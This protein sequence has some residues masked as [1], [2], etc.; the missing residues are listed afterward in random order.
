[1][2]ME[3]DKKLFKS[4]TISN[5]QLANEIQQLARS[6]SQEN[7]HHVAIKALLLRLYNSI[8]RLSGRRGHPPAPNKTIIEAYR[9]FF[10][11][12]EALAG[13]PMGDFL[14]ARMFLYLSSALI[15]DKS[16]NLRF[17]ESKAPASSAFLHEFC[18]QLDDGLLEPLKRIWIKDS[19]EQFHWVFTDCP[20]QRSEKSGIDPTRYPDL[21]QALSPEELK[22]IGGK[23]R[24]WFRSEHEDEPVWKAFCARLPDIDDQDTDNLL[25][26]D[27]GTD[28]PIFSGRVYRTLSKDAGEE[29][30]H[31]VPVLRRS[32]Q[33]IL[34]ARQISKPLITKQ[35]RHLLAG[36]LFRAAIP[37]EIREMI[38]AYMR[39]PPPP[40]QYNY[41]TGLDIAS[42][43]M[44][45]PKVPEPCQECKEK[46]LKRRD[47]SIKE[48]CPEHTI[49]VWNLL[50]RM[51]HVL[52]PEGN[53]GWWPCTEGLECCGHHDDEEWRVEDQSE[54]LGWIDS[55]ILD[56]DYEY[57]ELDDTGNGPVELTS[58]NPKEDEERRKRLFSENGPFVDVTEQ[59]KMEGGLCG[60][61]SVMAHKAAVIKA[62][63]D[64]GERR[65]ETAEV[66]WALGRNLVEQGKAEDTMKN[67]WH[68]SMRVCWFCRGRPPNFFSRRL[69]FPPLMEDSSDTDDD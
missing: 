61:L 24:Q 5:S 20:I 51:F 29:S 33:F 16:L 39:E 9:S 35:G 32:R 6:R 53:S 14:T 63:N 36:V 15:H 10:E 37:T 3:A 41:L 21:A 52:H 50:L 66:Q 11:P 60:P 58:L 38:W 68:G 19:L 43:Y 13:L 67:L 1:M 49:Y 4:L 54:L 42:A 69:Q 44:P 28:G 7:D 45:F 18:I 22:A 47:K 23:G 62:W 26:K 30:L 27:M 25:W 31:S 17:S 8:V 57:S 64:G 56:R 46:K 65:I 34:D 48:T 12:I 59:R 40:R 55:V 2:A